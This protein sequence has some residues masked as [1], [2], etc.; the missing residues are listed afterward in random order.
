MARPDF[1]LYVDFGMDGSFRT[2]ATPPSASDEITA[3]VNSFSVGPR[4]KNLLS[5]RAEASV[6]SA[7]LNNQTFKY[8]PTFGSPNPNVFPAPMTW[9]LMGYPVDT[10][11]APDGTTLSGRTPDYD[12]HANPW[13]GDVTHFQVASNQLQAKT[14]ANWQ[15]VVDFGESDCHVGANFTPTGATSGLILRY[16]DNQNFLLVHRP[17]VGTIRLS[18]VI[19]G[20]LAT[21]ASAS[22]SRSLAAGISATDT[23][24]S[25]YGDSGSVVSGTWGTTAAG[26][27]SGAWDAVSTTLAVTA[28]TGIVA[29]TVILVDSEQML[30]GSIEVGVSIT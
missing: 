7:I 20:S 25:L 14:A 1:H 26:A 22:I 10:F 19:A 23:I 16:Q 4:G 11:T 12:Q 9:V 21:I 13:A 30:V 27:V 3:D 5:Q 15:A 24:L 17:T 28:T 18:S 8:V 29:G 2:V 6:F